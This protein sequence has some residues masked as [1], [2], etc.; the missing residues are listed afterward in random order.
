[1]QQVIQIVKISLGAKLKDYMM[2]AKISL[3]IMLVFSCVVSYLLVPKIVAFNWEMIGWLFLA[4]ILVSGSANAVNQIIEKDIDAQMNRTA[5]RPIAAGRM[6]VEE[7]IVFAVVTGFIGIIILGILF[8]WQ[9]AFI[10]FISLILYAFVYTP[11]KKAG[12]IAVF[13][14]AVPGALPC[15]IGWVAGND[16]ISAGGLILFALQF[17]WQ[18]PHF[19]AIAW[20]ANDD[21][22]KAGLKLLPHE[23]SPTRITALQTIIYSFI[24]IPIGLLPFYFKMS[25]IISLVIVFSTTVFLIYRCVILYKNLNRTAARK[26]M[27]GSYIYLAIVLTSFLID[28]I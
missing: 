12:S 26:V 15:L 3:T 7:G 22:K 16:S 20:L 4:G 13:V 10:A 6:S 2:L 5:N 18:F 11:L 19:W 28:K 17:V 21:Y 23:S 24:L 8:N 14:G 9:A 1:M 25:G 27:F